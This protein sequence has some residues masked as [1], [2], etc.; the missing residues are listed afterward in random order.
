MTEPV[1]AS[2]DAAVKEEL[3]SEF[4]SDLDELWDLAEGGAT[5][6]E[7][8]KRVIRVVFRLARLLLLYLFGLLC[9]RATEKDIEARGLQWEEVKMRNDRDYCITIKTL[10]GEVTFPLFAYRESSSGVCWVTHVPAR[11]VF[12]LREYTRSSQLL[13]EWEIR[14]G[15]DHPYRHAEEALTFFTHGAVKVEDNTIADHLVK[16][17]RLV[18]RSWCYRPVEEIVDILQHRATR[19]EKTGRPILYASTDAENLRR[20]VDETWAA[21]WKHASGVRLWCEDQRTGALIHLGGEYTWGELDATR[22]VFQWLIDAGRLPADGDYGN[23]LVAQIVFPSDGIPWIKDHIIPMFSEDVAAILDPYHVMPRLADYAR[24]RHPRSKK[25]KSKWYSQAVDKLLGDAKRPKP[26][27]AK[28]RKLSQ[29]ERR[30]RA[31]QRQATRPL[32]VAMPE[33][34]A[35]KQGEVLLDWLRQE[36]KNIPKRQKKRAEELERLINYVKDNVDR[37]DYVRYRARGFKIGSGAMESLH[38]TT[39]VRLKLSGMRWLETTSQAL[40][41]IRMLVL[42]GRWEEFW[43]QRDITEQLVAAFAAAQREREVEQKEAA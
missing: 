30:K 42:V 29:Q 16:V 20:Y 27:T 31:Q 5:P 24:L 4:S 21:Q 33:A 23:G 10:V 12:P 17:A 38:R 43:A 14:L 19:D 2:C 15:S 25:L 9:R 6:V 41:N 26:K 13:L 3:L 18:D 35:P 8:Q 28:K 7:L 34:N 22:E 11:G 36:R 40:F 1:F 39:Q 37:M 32:R